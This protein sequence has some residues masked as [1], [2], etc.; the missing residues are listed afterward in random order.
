M[1]EGKGEA[2]VKV[3]S[4]WNLVRS[5]RGA[6]AISIPRPH[7]GF[8]LYSLSLRKAPGADYFTRAAITISSLC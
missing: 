8:I 3:I 6:R 1:G 4:S 7:P 2:T 5:E